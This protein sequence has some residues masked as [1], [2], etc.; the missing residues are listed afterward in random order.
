MPTYSSSPF[1]FEKGIHSGLN[2]AQPDG[3]PSCMVLVLCALG[4]KASYYEPLLQEFASKGIEAYGF[5]WRGNGDSNI[6]PSGKND[7]GYQV[8]MDDILRVIEHL[9][10]E[11][12]ELPLYLVGHSLGGQIACLLNARYPGRVAG[13]MVVAS[14]IPYYKPYPKK[15][16]K[17]IR[18]AGRLF[19]VVGSL[20]GYVPGKRLGFGGKMEAKTLMKDWSYHAKNGKFIL[21]N[22]DFDYEEAIAKSQGA[23]I[24]G[25]ALEGDTFAPPEAVAAMLN[26]FVNDETVK[27]EFITKEEYGLE[28]LNHF[29]WVKSPSTIVKRFEKFRVV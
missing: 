23:N 25:I 18:I 29:S 7:W 12:P 15:E 20:L 28:K 14:C 11:N 4:V 13:T 26:K 2:H 17:L 8:L 24:L 16:Q 27:Q 19:P 5:D 3:S 10:V 1:E 9:R 22:S 21:K 6:R